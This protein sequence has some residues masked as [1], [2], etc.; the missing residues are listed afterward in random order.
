MHKS[1]DFCI[2]KIVWSKAIRGL[3]NSSLRG[4][5]FSEL[6]EEMWVL[7]PEAGG[8]YKKAVVSLE[9]NTTET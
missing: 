3:K 5:Q 2:A 7:P 8:S 6:S 4:Y 1:R 9:Q